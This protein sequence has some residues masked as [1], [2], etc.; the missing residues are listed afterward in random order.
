[1]KYPSIILAGLSGL[2][3]ATA[4][5]QTLTLS[6]SDD[7]TITSTNASLNQGNATNLSVNTDV[8]RSL[9]KFDISV[10]ANSIAAGDLSVADISSVKLVLD[11]SQNDDN[12]AKGNGNTSRIDISPLAVD[13][14]EG[15]VSWDCASSAYC[16]WSGGEFG[17]AS[18]E[19]SVNDIT[20]G[21]VQL[22]VTADLISML[23]NDSNYGWLIKKLQEDK[24]GAISFSAKEAG[25]STSPQLMVTLSQS[26]DLL[27]PTV[28]ISKPSEPFYLGTPPEQ[29]EVSYSDDLDGINPATGVTISLDG[30]DI[31]K[32]NCDL[33]SVSASCSMSDLSNGTHTIEA[34]VED[35]GG[36]LSSVKK[37]FV[38][39]ENQ[40]AGL[41]GQWLTGAGAPVNGIGIDGDMYLNT[42]TDGKGDV[43]KKQGGNWVLEVN[44]TGERG[45]NGTSGTSSWTDGSDQVTT[46]VKVGIGVASPVNALDVEGN[47]SGYAPVADNHFVTKGFM[48][49]AVETLEDKI[50]SGND[51][52][53]D[54]MDDDWETTHG[55]DPASAADAG[56]DAD[57]DGATNL[58]EFK[59]GTNPNDASDV[60]A[61]FEH[62][63]DGDTQIDGAL[64]LV[65]QAV[66]PMTCDAEAEGSTYYNSTVKNRYECDGDTWQL[67]APA[68]LLCPDDEVVAGFDDRGG[69]VCVKKSQASG[70]GYYWPATTT[71]L[72]ATSLPAYYTGIDLLGQDVSLNV[73]QGQYP[74]TDL[75]GGG[76]ATVVLSDDGSDADLTHIS[77]DAQVAKIDLNGQSS[78]LTVQQQNMELIGLDSAAGAFQVNSYSERDQKQVASTTLDNGDVVIVW[79]NN[80]DF[81]IWGQ[82]Y[83]KNRVGIGGNFKISQS[84]R[85]KSKPAITAVD[86]GGFVVAWESH[87]QDY[88]ATLGVYARRYSAEAIALE[89]EFPVNTYVYNDQQRPN[90]SRLANGGF[91]IVWD[92]E[93]QNTD[94]E[95][96]S[97]YAQKYDSDG[98]A[99][100]TE[101]LI[102]T[103]LGGNNNSP[104]ITLFDDNVVITWNHDE[105][106]NRNSIVYGKKYDSSGVVIGEKFT[107]NTGGH[108]IYSELS[109]LKS[110]GFVAAWTGAGGGDRSNQ[111]VFAQR[112]DYRGEKVSDMFLVNTLTTNHQNF[113]MITPLNNGGFVIAWANYGVDFA[114]SMGRRYSASFQVYSSEGFPVGG[115]AV[116]GYSY[117]VA[118]PT[119]T[120][121]ADGGFLVAWDGEVE[122]GEPHNIYAQRFNLHGLPMGPATFSVNDVISNLLSEAGDMNRATSVTARVEAEN[123]DLT[124]NNLDNDVTHIDIMGL[125]VLL[126]AAQK[127]QYTIV[128]SVGGGSY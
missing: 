115:E 106:L 70:G 92:S 69:L 120:N 87:G 97:I 105:Q 68:G 17:I 35:Q 62:L 51:A 7:A 117:T 2:L 82:R 91:I 3:S 95:R 37:V 9:V 39:N 56:Q 127:S 10:L 101:E 43:Y 26:V 23:N 53:G 45:V 12:W 25:A 98:L 31:T 109:S 67:R 4:T 13:W 27:P 102:N 124:D 47:V 113:P 86:G 36:K 34:F 16:G 81:K 73:A 84:M 58:E 77:L 50:A 128:D 83:D 78:V 57:S 40:S 80:S 111:A 76:S 94:G 118:F 42:A 64:R 11:V 71:D 41:G 19:L 49:T 14:L 116:A 100:G 22:D 54:G 103:D 123:T 59:A 52:D 5:A 110:G 72:T 8:A 121:M 74:I 112:F 46:T 33:G 18:A 1:M 55:L 88:T 32:A 125:D 79:V 65:P 24:A 44:I 6:V 89:D 21:V 20:S 107:L 75:T 38:F 93:Y 85:D 28:T 63:N 104:A 96:Y 30:V 99:I 114:V 66:P 15:E 108:D 126:T 60:P 90:I 119:V 48:D 29:I 122:E 61:E